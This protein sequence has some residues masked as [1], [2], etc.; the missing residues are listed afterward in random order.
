[1]HWVLWGGIIMSYAKTNQANHF[2]K[3][4]HFSKLY[5]QTIPPQHI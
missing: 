4:A 1:M 3:A 2:Y 5:T